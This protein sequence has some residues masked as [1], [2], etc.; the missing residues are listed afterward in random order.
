MNIFIIPV[1]MGNLSLV[2][3]SYF[4]KCGEGLGTRLGYSHPQGRRSGHQTWII[5]CFTV[6]TCI[7]SP[8]VHFLSVRR[9]NISTDDYD[10]WTT[11]SSSNENM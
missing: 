3:K 5:G 10:P 2:P 4:R 9:Y 6:E 8:K 7:D 1:T 11:D